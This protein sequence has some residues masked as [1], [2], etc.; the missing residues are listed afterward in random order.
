MAFTRCA[1]A[2]GAAH[3]V[4]VNAISPSLAEHPFLNR[5]ISDEDLALLRGRERFGRGA[6]TWEVA[7][8]VVFLASDYSS[9]LSGEIIAVSSQHP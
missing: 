5:V 8:V 1:A 6:E 3:G 9:Y 4:R 7:N 2:E